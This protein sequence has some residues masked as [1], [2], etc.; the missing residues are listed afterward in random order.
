MNR[1]S[2]LTPATL[3]LAVITVIMTLAA[4]W[5]PYALDNHLFEAGLLRRCPDGF[6]WSGYADYIN[7][8]RQV[9]NWRLPNILAPVVSL[10][11]PKWLFALLTGLM[12]A[13]NVYAAASFST[14]TADRSNG[15]L[16]QTQA[17]FTVLVF[18]AMLVFLPWGNNILTG[19]YALNY[20][21][22]SFIAMAM[23]LSA[24]AGIDR[25][26]GSLLPALLGC[27]LGIW[28]EGIAM[29]AVGGV[30]IMAL[31]LRFD[32][33]YLPYYIGGI[34]AFVAALVWMLSSHLT[35]RADSEFASAAICN[36]T[37]RFVRYNILAIVM[38]VVV[39]GSLL[40]RRRRAL[41]FVQARPLSAL[42]AGSMLTALCISAVTAF[43]GRAAFWG[44][45]S[46]IVTLG[47]I[48]EPFIIRRSRRILTATVG[49]VCVTLCTTELIF[50]RAFNDR[51]EAFVGSLANSPDGTVYGPAYLPK[52]FPSWLPQ[53][54]PR[55]LFVEPFTY[56]VL[57]DR[58]APRHAAIVPVEFGMIEFDKNA[59][60]VVVTSE[61]NMYMNPT[62]EITE[63]T[64]LD[65]IGDDT[66]RFFAI[67]FPSR[68]GPMICIYPID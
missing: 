25:R 10:Y 1:Q 57:S 44:E 61:G 33:R 28:H 38:T 39:L 11:V 60:G 62:P 55:N 14:G 56:T 24:R 50:C 19:D 40:F 2:V 37:L 23:F 9:D 7:A 16:P 17:T 52:D 58:Y 29:A 3:A 6:T 63:P 31:T 22:G 41:D 43:S 18:A 46:A 26:R 49:L 66:R 13:T 51:Y 15:H 48:A 8:I 68:Y 21:W 67:P 45:M 30:V 20:I 12:T 4:Y 34:A 5:T 32:R 54:V 42:F 53:F 47:I 35:V 59:T 64:V 27:L 36:D 65:G